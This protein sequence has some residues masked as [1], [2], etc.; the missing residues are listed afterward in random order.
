MLAE[1]GLL[2][3][4]ISGP[5]AQQAG[6]PTGAVVESGFAN[7]GYFTKWAD[8]TMQC[9][10]MVAVDLGHENPQLF[11]YPDPMVVAFGGQATGANRLEADNAYRANAAYRIKEVGRMPVWTDTSGWMLQ[12]IKAEGQ[13][14]IDMHLSA[15]GRW[16]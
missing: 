15:F 12:V 14:T 1:H 5:V 11:D 9:H 3:S 7:G 2:R 10:R 4:D 16:Y 6:V 13:D 8:G